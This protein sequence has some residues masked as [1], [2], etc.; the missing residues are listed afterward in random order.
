MPTPSTDEGIG[1]LNIGATTGGLPLA[2]MKQP[3]PKAG[4]FHLKNKA[5]NT[6]DTVPLA[7]AQDGEHW[8]NYI[9]KYSESVQ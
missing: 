3:C 2:R 4:K 5:K 1:V 6:A 9:D 8:V 7:L